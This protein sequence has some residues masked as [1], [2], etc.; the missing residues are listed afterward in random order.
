MAGLRNQPKHPPP[1]Q[2][3]SPI[4]SDN[5]SVLGVHFDSMRVDWEHEDESDVE[6]EVDLDDYDDEEFGAILAEMVEKEEAKDLDWL[7]PRLRI[8]M[9]ER[10]GAC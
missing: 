10:K 8:K 5:E 9:K 7:P 4:D 3:N 2:D 1:T 6:S